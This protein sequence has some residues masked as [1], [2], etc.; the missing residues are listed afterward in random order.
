MGL[1][2]ADILTPYH[3]ILEFEFREECFRDGEI[4]FSEE[5]QFLEHG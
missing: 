2:F 3:T 4:G 5:G 1:V